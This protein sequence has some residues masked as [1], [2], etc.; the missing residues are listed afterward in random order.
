M[1]KLPLKQKKQYIL[2][3]DADAFFASV[4]QILNPTLKGRPVLVGG[5]TATKGIVSAASYEARVFG[6]HSGMPMY[7]A[8]KKCPNAIVVPGNFDA[9]RDFSKKMYQIFA[10]HTPDIEMCSIDEA[11]LDITGYAEAFSETPE[12]F[13][14]MIMMEIYGKLGLSVSCG[15]ASGKTVAK[16]ASSINKPHKFTMV[17]YGKEAAF[18]APL[19]LK[20]IPGIGPKTYAIL[21][22]Y[23]FE[24]IGELSSLSMDEVLKKFGIRGIPLWKRAQ[25][26][27]NSPVIS[28][29]SLPKSISK[30]HTF[31]SE[32][33]QTEICLK[34][35][36]RLSGIVFGKLRSHKMKAKTV[37]VR[38]RY[39]NTNV[40]GPIF[41]DFSF[42]TNLAVS[43]SL[44]NKLFPVVK[45]LFLR[46]Y[47]GDSPVRLIGVGV[48]NLSQNY[49]LSLF[50]NEEDEKL[51]FNIDVLKNLYGDGI[52]NYGV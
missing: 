42:Q 39:K 33:R 17:K 13:A 3:I 32:G 6:I 11:Y 34:E 26:F 4:E 7:L 27:D 2:H 51:F 52:V 45:E 20:A 24:K 23:G 16:V 25:G 47:A 38:I 28:T 37:F 9:Y 22:R 44:D 15:L 12:L 8:T 19:S 14:K 41:Q 36:K 40:D 30:E 5:P 50:E 29:I 46:N 43:S 49:N 1:F 18:L 31:Y 10:K 21:E 35:L 48:T